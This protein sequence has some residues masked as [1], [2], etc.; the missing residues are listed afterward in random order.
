M[1]R[2]I[3]LV[4]GMVF[5]LAFIIAQEAPPY[6]FSYKAIITNSKG[7]IIASKTIGLKISILQG[8]DI[9]DP[10]Y[11][12]TFRPTTSANGQIDIVIGRGTAG[13]LSSINWSSNKYFLKTEVDARGGTDYQVMGVPT[14]LLSV[15]YSLYS[16]EAKNGFASVFTPT[17]KRPIIDKN[18]N[19]SIGEGTDP[20]WKLN[21]KGGAKA[22]WLMSHGDIA[23]NGAIWAQPGY[24][25]YGTVISLN[26]TVLEGGVDFWIASLAGNAHE[27]QGK[28]MIKPS[29]GHPYDAFIMDKDGNVGLGLPNYNPNYRLDVYGDIN[30]TGEL[31]KNGNPFSVD[32]STLTNK[33]AGN[34]VG[35]MQYWDGTNWK[36]I[37]VGSEGQVL[38]MKDGIPTWSKK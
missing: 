2:I 22:G 6:E 37:P 38:T 8:S 30:F 14:E 9:G 5:S 3:T 13:N 7:V 20:N 23:L 35:D 27:G 10:V 34:N 4:I 18:G 33:P 29:S 25:T 17:E 16:G 12:E 32:Y 24:L 36:V 1:K 31:Y 15:P 26:S 28:L 21:V 19:I 11:S